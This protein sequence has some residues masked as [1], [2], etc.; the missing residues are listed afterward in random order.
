MKYVLDSCVALKWVLAEPDS[1][2][3]I[4]VRDDDNRGIHELLAPDI[5]VVEV[6]HA[7]AR[8]ERRGIISPPDGTRRL[9][10]VSNN[11]PALH[12]YLSLL[13]RAFAIASQFRTGVYDC[14]Y[15]ALAEREVCK[16][17]TADDRLIR[18][19][20][21]TFPFVTSLASLP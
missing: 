20:K 17:L 2:K 6:A 7:L 15:V 19:L 14:L 5:F 4:Q 9:Q 18:I 1:D 21:P 10:N 13:S 11:M 3:A 16:H 8:A 12:S